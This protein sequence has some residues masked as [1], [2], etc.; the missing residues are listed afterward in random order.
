M[1]ILLAFLDAGIP[2][3]HS[4][5][6]VGALN[7]RDERPWRQ[8]TNGRKMDEIGLARQLAPYGIRPR[9]IRIGD[10][11][12]RG[13]TQ[14]DF[15]EAFRRYIPASEAEEARRE[16]QTERMKDEQG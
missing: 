6:L 7:L 3:L 15:A 11:I 2:R 12:A 1:D 5:I 13:Y 4:R 16:A 9:N 8:L 14:E 10:T